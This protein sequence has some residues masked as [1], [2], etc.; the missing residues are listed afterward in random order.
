MAGGSTDIW[1][2]V[3]KTYGDVVRK[4]EQRYGLYTLLLPLFYACTVCVFNSAVLVEV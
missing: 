1:L 4:V 2:V 3:R